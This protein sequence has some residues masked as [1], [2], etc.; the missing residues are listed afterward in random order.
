MKRHR[1]N[2]FE[3]SQLNNFVMQSF[4]GGAGGFYGP[5]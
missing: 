3:L 1:E 2:Q 4:M 5:H